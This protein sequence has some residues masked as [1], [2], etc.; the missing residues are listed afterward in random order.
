[1]KEFDPSGVLLLPR[2]WLLLLPAL[3]GGAL[4]RCGSKDTFA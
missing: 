2:P 1:V 3:A 4:L